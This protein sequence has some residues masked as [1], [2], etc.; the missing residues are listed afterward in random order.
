MHLFISL[1]SHSVCL[2]L[3]LIVA[4]HNDSMLTKSSLCL[5]VCESLVCF[6]ITSL[7]LMCR[8]LTC[9]SPVCCSLPYLLLTDLWFIQLSLAGL[10]VN[11]LL[12][13]CSFVTHFTFI[14]SLVTPLFYSIFFIFCCKGKIPHTR[15]QGT[16]KIPSSTILHLD[17]FSQNR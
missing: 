12:V 17:N 8:S 1:T 13:T 9:F 10:I 4:V 2:L 14:D 7:L 16:S 6:Q 3:T 5:I 11:Q 15:L